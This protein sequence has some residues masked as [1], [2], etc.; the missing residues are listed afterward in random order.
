MV[1][2]LWKLNGQEKK[3]LVEQYRRERKYAAGVPEKFSRLINNVKNWSLMGLSF[4]I[5]LKIF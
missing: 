1:F 3:R 5:H 4:H 2:N